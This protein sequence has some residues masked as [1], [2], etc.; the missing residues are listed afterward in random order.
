MIEGCDEG[1]VLQAGPRADGDSGCWYNVFDTVLIVYTRRGIW[2]QS[3]LG[4]IGSSVNR[5]QFYSVRIGQMV[6]TGIQ[7]DAGDTNTFMGCSF[8][9]V[10]NGTQPSATPTAILIKKKSASGY[11]N[12]HNTFFGARFE[13]NSV[14]LENH[15]GYTELYGSNVSFG[16][17][18]FK[19]IYPLYAVGG[20]DPSVTPLLMPGIAYPQGS[21]PGYPNRVNFTGDVTVHG[22][23]ATQNDRVGLHA[24]AEDLKVYTELV[25]D[26]AHGANGQVAKHTRGGQWGLYVND[27]GRTLRKGPFR[28]VHRYRLT[29]GQAT[30]TIYNS[31]RS[32][33]VEVTNPMP[34]KADGRYHTEVAGYFELDNENPPDETLRSFYSVDKSNS[35]FVEWIRIEEAP[36]ESRRSL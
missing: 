15:N 9:G 7:I 10:E 11:A 35:L 2:L 33:E 34:L 36:A 13:A 29:A 12:N 4:G 6:N 28:I 27:L 5:N 8:E 24:G 32:H 16:T 22:Q 18:K 26:A 20:S 1:I 21:L 31:S 19:G 17:G 30:V 3:P 23:L 14:D 25:D